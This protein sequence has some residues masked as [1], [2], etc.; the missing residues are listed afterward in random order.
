MELAVSAVHGHKVLSGSKH[1]RNIFIRIPVIRN[2]IGGQDLVQDRKLKVP[3]GRS[4][5]YRVAFIL[6]G[7]FGIAAEIILCAVSHHILLCQLAAGAAAACEAESQK[8]CDQ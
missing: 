4:K 1:R 6:I 8:E 2:I 7:I 3:A 5:M